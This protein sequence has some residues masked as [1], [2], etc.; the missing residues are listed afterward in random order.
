[1]CVNTNMLTSRVFRQLNISYVFVI[2]QK[3]ITEVCRVTH[4]AALCPWNS[5]L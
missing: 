3:E 2:K 1:M 4:I 5:L